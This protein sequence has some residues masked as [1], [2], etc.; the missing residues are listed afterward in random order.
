MEC[1][2]GCVQGKDGGDGVQVTQAVS[3][4][5]HWNQNRGRDH[6]RDEIESENEGENENEN[7]YLLSASDGDR[8]D[9]YCAYEMELHVNVSVHPT[10][11]SK[12]C[13]LTKLRI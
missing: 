2:Y 7:D 3:E 12:S 9:Q 6:V 1:V 8:P 11:H 13:A 5:D 4:S 10:K